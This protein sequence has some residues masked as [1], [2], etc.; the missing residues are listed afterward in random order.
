MPK[1]NKYLKTIV[2]CVTF[3]FTHLSHKDILFHD[4]QYRQLHI[5]MV[6][7]YFIALLL[8]W[9]TH[10]LVTFSG[11]ASSHVFLPNH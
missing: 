10:T 2:I 4:F 3:Y 11:L 5:L 7:I 9:T 8:I 6:K 1:R